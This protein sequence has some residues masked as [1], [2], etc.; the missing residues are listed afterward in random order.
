MKKFDLLL[1]EDGELPEGKILI[2]LE[3]NSIRPKFSF[4]LDGR[5]Y[6]TKKFICKICRKPFEA[7]SCEKYHAFTRLTCGHKI[8]LED[9]EKRVFE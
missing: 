5:L 2:P 3:E 8:F 6:F 1:K 7:L 4:E 9:M